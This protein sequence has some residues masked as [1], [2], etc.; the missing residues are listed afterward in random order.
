[1]RSSVRTL[2]SPP[3]AAESELA[4]GFDHDLHDP[5]I[6]WGLANDRAEIGK[7]RFALAISGDA[8][9]VDVQA[10][11]MA[12]VAPSGSRGRPFGGRRFG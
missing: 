4:I 10:A 3:R 11:G 12:S 7:K 5:Q 9:H 1:M 2:P 8:A 6:A